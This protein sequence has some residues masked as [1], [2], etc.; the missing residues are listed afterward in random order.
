[1]AKSSKASAAPR[2]AGPPQAAIVLNF[3]G[4]GPPSDISIYSPDNTITSTTVTATG[5][6]TPAGATVDGYVYSSTT[7]QRYNSTGAV[8]SD[9][10]GIWRNLT[11]NVPA[12]AAGDCNLKAFI[13]VNAQCAEVATDVVSFYVSPFGEILMFLKHL[14][15]IVPADGSSDK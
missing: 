13:V 4:N 5:S 12:G 9:A 2:P 1:M 3:P 11:F 7:N 10:G 6:V 8:V 15:K 14:A